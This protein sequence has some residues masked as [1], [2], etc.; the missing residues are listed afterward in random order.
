MPTDPFVAPDLDD[1]P[2][3]QQNLPAGVAYPPSRDLKEMRPGRLGA[4]PQGDELPGSAGPN[5]GYGY[6]LAK[7]AG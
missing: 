2:R 7:K 4:E 3:Q 6:T 5:V 1:N